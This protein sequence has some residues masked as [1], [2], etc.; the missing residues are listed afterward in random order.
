MSDP[1]ADLRPL[2]AEIREMQARVTK[3]Y[4]EYQVLKAKN[5]E[6][7]PVPS[8]SP[9]LDGDDLNYAL[10]ALSK[11]H[12]ARTDHGWRGRPPTC[13]VCA[14]LAKHGKAVLS[15]T[16]DAQG[17]PSGNAGEPEPT[18]P[19]GVEGA[20]NPSQREGLATPETSDV[21]AGTE[22]GPSGG[23][24]QAGTASDEKVAGGDDR[25]GVV[26][27]VDAPDLSKPCPVCDWPISQHY[28]EQ[29]RTCL[30]KLIEPPA[31]E[32]LVD[33]AP[34]P[35][36]CP[37]GCEGKGYVVSW[38]GTRFACRETA[39]FRRLESGASPVDA[40]TDT[41]CP[42]IDTD[43]AQCTLSTGHEGTHR[44]A[45]DVGADARADLEGHIDSLRGSLTRCSAD[46][47]RGKQRIR[48]LERV[49]DEA[50]DIAEDALDDAKNL[51][52]AVAVHRAEVM[53]AN[54]R[55]PEATGMYG[56]QIVTADVNLWRR[57]GLEDGP[58]WEQPAPG[59]SQ[60]API[61]PFIAIECDTNDQAERVFAMVMSHMT[62]RDTYDNRPRHNHVGD[63]IVSMTLA[64]TE[65]PGGDG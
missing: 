8:A 21:T 59:A 9:D 5:A 36:D 48:H 63:P 56:P 65:S 24:D 61:K 35:S 13:Y 27:G 25:S 18:S 46:V 2:V 41:R 19:P 26:H 49:L 44:A 17:A 40:G 62:A 54:T 3:L 58:V 57:A 31:Q 55:W 50:K 38:S 20:P 28:Y 51:R 42:F 1:W 12:L 39:P 14:L 37:G 43:D 33:D 53:R 64:D 16:S 34:H 4:D 30:W 15:N 22:N 29:A 32:E 52:E 60:A 10:E 7:E 23:V 11:E 47:A 45:D 6:D